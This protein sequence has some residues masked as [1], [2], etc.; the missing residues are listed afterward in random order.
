MSP[1]T[2]RP[3]SALTM[4]VAIAMPAEGPSFGVA[5]AGMWTWMSRLR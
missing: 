4:A 3:V 5:P 2:G 1:R